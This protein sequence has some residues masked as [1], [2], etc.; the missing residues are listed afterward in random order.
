MH[1][2]YVF[3]RFSSAAGTR[4]EKRGSLPELLADARE[5]AAIKTDCQMV[6]LSC[7][8][9]TS[10]R[11]SRGQP[12]NPTG[13]LSVDIDIEP[14]GGWA[15]AWETLSQYPDIS[16]MESFSGK[17]AL[18]TPLPS[19]VE[20][21]KVFKDLSKALAR[22]LAERVNTRPDTSATDI[23]RGRFIWSG[24]KYTLGSAY[25]GDHDLPG[26]GY[27]DACWLAWTY[28]RLGL[29]REDLEYL[30]NGRR[31][32]PEVLDAEYA[33]GQTS[34]VEGEAQDL[35]QALEAEGAALFQVDRTLHLVIDD[36]PP[37]MGYHEVVRA[38]AATIRRP[39]PFTSKTESLLMAKVPEYRQE[40]EL[41]SL[42]PPGDRETF[43]DHMRTLGTIWRLSPAGIGALARGTQ[44]LV[45]HLLYR[46]R[47]DECLVLVGGGGLGKSRYADELFLRISEDMQVALIPDHCTPT[48]ED[49]LTAIQATAKVMVLDEFSVQELGEDMV[50]A[51]ISETRTVRRKYARDS[52]RVPPVPTVLT[53]N[54]ADNVIYTAGVPD[55]RMLP[56]TLPFGLPLIE[57]EA[58]G[59]AARVYVREHGPEIL[60]GALQGDWVQLSTEDRVEL[61]DALHLF[62]GEESA[63][64]RLRD[65][66]DRYGRLIGVTQH[67]NMDYMTWGFEKPQA[68]K[69]FLAQQ[70][71]IRETRDRVVIYRVPE[72]LLSPEPMP[73]EAPQSL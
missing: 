28:G 21:P 30:T 48:N 22:R 19:L 67:V 50:K 25:F 65:M 44:A 3:P 66:V 32:T 9:V 14:P 24:M 37:I 57:A 64:E 46:E 34:E 29:P 41:L 11:P 36:Q 33:K 7:S 72:E 8:P 1:L 63:L 56:V 39:V 27:P 53:T 12:G 35:M 26:E 47:T 68:M 15:K 60:A 61:A 45:R 70:G 73:V 13:V 42:L 69:V 31:V 20:D 62:R 5:K 51:F 2:D 6:L 52:T 71:C 16:L 10:D 23:T 40:A 4:V 59:R 38:I 54:N 58:I 55:R 49:T 18:F 43:W 17:I